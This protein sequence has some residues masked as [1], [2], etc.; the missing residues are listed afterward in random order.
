MNNN[1]LVGNSAGGPAAVSGPSN[2]TTNNYTN[3]GESV[4]S[5]PGSVVGHYNTSQNNMG[6]N[7]IDVC[8]TSNNQYG[9]GSSIVGVGSNNIS[10]K[11][12]M[13]KI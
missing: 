11:K 8:G 10:V 13:M 12:S 7:D 5:N 2:P 1:N 9:G 3:L 6:S 4:G